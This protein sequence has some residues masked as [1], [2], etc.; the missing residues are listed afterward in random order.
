MRAGAVS[1]VL[2]VRSPSCFPLEVRLPLKGPRFS[3]HAHRLP[4]ARVALFGSAWV[5]LFSSARVALFGVR[6]VPPPG[7]GL[8][9]TWVAG[10]Y[11]GVLPGVRRVPSSWAE[12][13]GVGLRSLSWGTPRRSPRASSTALSFGLGPP[14]ALPAASFSR[15][16]LRTISVLPIER[17]PS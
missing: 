5:A 8:C 14:T 15:C 11:R 1:P 10:P 12:L 17:N 4:S 13:F 2:V 9:L 6:R 3:A 7:R 16:R